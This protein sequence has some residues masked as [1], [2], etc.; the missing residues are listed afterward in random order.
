MFAKARMLKVLA[1][2][3][4]GPNRRKRCTIACRR[5][6]TSIA[7]RQNP[8]AFAQQCRAMISNRMTHREVFSMDRTCF[9][10]HK[11]PQVDF[12]LLRFGHAQCRS[13]LGPSQS[14]AASEGRASEGQANDEEGAS[15]VRVSE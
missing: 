4:C 2:R 6:A 3:M 5:E 7:M 11:R 8:A 13:Q 14:L 12:S 1:L 15:E 10:Q 9:V